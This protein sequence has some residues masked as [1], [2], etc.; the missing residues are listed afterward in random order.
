MKFD[1]LSKNFKFGHNFRM[2]SDRA[3]VF[4]MHVTCDKTFI[5]EILTLGFDDD[6]H[7]WNLPHT[8]A[9]VFHITS[10]FLLYYVDVTSHR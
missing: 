4:H 9:F 10:C 2:A 3:L 7:L 8:G 5:F 6:D 1:R